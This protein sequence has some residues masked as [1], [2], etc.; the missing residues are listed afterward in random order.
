[1]ID[2]FLMANL[3]PGPKHGYQ[4]KKEA[5]VILGEKEL[6]NNTVYPL[7]HRLEKKKWINSRVVPGN[8]GQV[9]REYVLTRTGRK[10]LLRRAASPADKEIESSPAFFF[11]VGLFPTLTPE[12]R[13]YI[14]NAREKALQTKTQQVARMRQEMDL[15]A[16]GGEVVNFFQRR[17]RLELAWIKHLR[18]LAHHPIKC[19]EGE[20][21]P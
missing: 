4:L 1:M 6:H 3:L 7:L 18:R 9:R 5:R 2:L 15:G 10:E 20:A 11:R 17:T 12:Q 13:L 21:S 19:V 16:Y 14:L 8:R